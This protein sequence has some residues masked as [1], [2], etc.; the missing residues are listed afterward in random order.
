MAYDVGTVHSSHTD[1]KGNIVNYV[2]KYVVV[3]RRDASGEWR[4]AGDISN[5]D[6]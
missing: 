4:V 5:S 2:G 1:A 3:W 6:G